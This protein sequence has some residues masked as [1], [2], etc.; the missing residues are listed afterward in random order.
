MQRRFD[1]P[2]LLAMAVFLASIAA[3]VSIIQIGDTW[4]EPGTDAYARYEGFNRSMAVLL[5]VQALAPVAFL[6]RSLSR[7]GRVPRLALAILALGILGSALFT[8]AEFWLFT[9]L[10]YARDN[11]RTTAFVLFGFSSL[12]Q[13]AGLVVFGLAHLRA[14]GEPLWLAVAA[15]LYPAVEIGLFIGT[16]SIFLAPTLLAV[17]FA[18]A[19]ISVARS[20]GEAR[21]AAQGLA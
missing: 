4:G 10:P 3:I 7:L 17:V 6:L 21:R 20:G 18:L 5:A 9:D 14:R 2:T 8:A 19:T 16:S 11:A 13:W 15:L 12:I 1:L